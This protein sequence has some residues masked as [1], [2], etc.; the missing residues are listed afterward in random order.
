MLFSKIFAAGAV[1]AATA[2]A[3]LTPAQI[4]DSLKTVTVLSQNLQGQ[5]QSIT[6]V[7]APLTIIGQGPFPPIIAGF[8]QIVTTATTAISQFDGTAKITNKADA[9]LVFNAFRAFV[10]VHQELLNILIGKSG[11]LTQVPFIGPPVAAVLRSVEGVVDSI[12]I[13][14]INTVEVYTIEIE[15]EANSL[16]NTL[17]LTISKYEGLSV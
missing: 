11:L 6:I 5:A 4:A 12:A 8:T 9:D 1:M 7:N 17:D 15:S 16:G 14:L 3:A 10:R 13:F 2:M